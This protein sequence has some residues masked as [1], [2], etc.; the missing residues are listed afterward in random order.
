MRVSGST[1]IT[2]TAR[3]SSARVNSPVPAARS[4]ATSQ[5]GGTSQS[6]AAA[7]GPGRTLS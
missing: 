5:P 7:G 2:R 4:T 1:A 3:P 6:M